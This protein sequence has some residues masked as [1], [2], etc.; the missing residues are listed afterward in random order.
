[1]ILEYVEMKNVRSHTDSRIEFTNGI[2]V[3]TGNTGSGKSS[4]LMSI[5]YCLFG[6]IADKSDAGM[7]LRR[8]TEN[9]SLELGVKEDDQSYTVKRGLKRIKENVRNDD[10]MNKVLKEGRQVDLQNRATDLNVY[11]ASL[12]GI[13]SE[14]PRRA[15]EAITYIKQ[16]ELKNLIFET[17]QEKQEYIDSLLQLDRYA[18]TYDYMKAIIDKIKNELDADKKAILFIEG[19]NELIKLEKRRSDIGLRLEELNAKRDV[20]ERELGLASSNINKT[21]S[22]IKFAMEAKEKHYIAASRLD[23][24]RA[25]LQKNKREEKELEK[26]LEDTEIN[27]LKTTPEKETALIN[28]RREKNTLKQEKERGLNKIRES[29]YKTNSELT[30]M[31][32]TKDELDTSIKEYESKLEALRRTEESLKASISERKNEPDADELSGRIEQLNETIDSLNREKEQSLSDKICKMCGSELLDDSHLQKEY[33]EKISK[34]KGE[35]ERYKNLIGANKIPKKTLELNLGKLGVEIENALNSFEISKEKA[36]KIDIAS[37]KS[38]LENHS[39]QMN[40]IVSEINGL[41]KQISAIDKELEELVNIRNKINEISAAKNILVT[42]KKSNSSIEEE[43][44]ILEKE[45]EEIKFDGAQVG[46]LESDLRQAREVY[47]KLSTESAESKRE[48]EIKNLE[49]QEL[50]GQFTALKEKITKR[51]SLEAKIRSDESL[52]EKLSGLRDDIKDI[53][54]YVRDRF[55]EEF[56]SNFQ[57]KFN[58]IRSNTDYIV[59]IDRD[60]NLNVIAENEVMD[61]R[62]LSGGEKTSV[63]LAYR[64]AL[65]SI[66]STLGGI[67]KNELLIMDEPTSG[68][69]K[70]DINA[71]SDAITKIKGIKQIIIVTHEDTMKNIADRNIIISKPSGNSIVKISDI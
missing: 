24:K 69:D 7:I 4:I 2:N 19:E 33:A 22:E 12:L 43:M 15:F 53:R 46:V 56:K 16:D 71:L 70:E 47:N 3:I 38:D 44:A 41:D 66:A 18:K 26:K 58:E 40:L 68:L 8:R 6:K 32:K 39:E 67:S 37:K 36:L 23:E 52:Y 31:S 27:E 21:E 25:T 17:T 1:M 50:N 59:D 65:S 51:K 35:I 5:E 30:A 34:C 49:L 55:I 13:K 11:I 63:A 61:A 54:G 45:L 28:E 20:L 64:I 48:M 57:I 14:S 10:S 60:Y 42:L 62:S 9:G 29:F